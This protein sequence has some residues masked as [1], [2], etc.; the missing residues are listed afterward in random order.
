M[1]DMPVPRQVAAVLA[2]T[3]TV[4]VAGIL[5]SERLIPGFNTPAIE[6]GVV[7]TVCGISWV[8]FVVLK[9]TDLILRRISEMEQ[10]EVDREHAQ[11]YLGSL[12]SLQ[13]HR[14]G[15]RGDS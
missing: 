1:A 9:C 3:S 6:F 12:R 15:H 2:S 7:L 14:T 5:L 4:V 10:R 11:Y 8:S 13:Q